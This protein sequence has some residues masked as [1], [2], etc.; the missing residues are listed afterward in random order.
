M[1][2]GFKFFETT[3]IFYMLVK[4]KTLV[5]QSTCSKSHRLG[6]CY[7]IIYAFL[8]RTSSNF[9][10]LEKKDISPRNKLDV[11]LI[12]TVKKVLDFSL[13]YDCASSDL[14]DYLSGEG[15]VTF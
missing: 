4:Q 7:A 1:Q 8:S 14:Q 11:N 3:C 5:K 9:K 13:E 12:G 15:V 6:R 2:N 10:F